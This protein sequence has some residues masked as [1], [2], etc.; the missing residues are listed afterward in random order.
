MCSAWI[1][2]WTMKYTFQSSILPLLSGGSE[3]ADLAYIDCFLTYNIDFIYYK[4]PK[5]VG[6]CVVI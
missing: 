4:I 5:L 2:C 6:F 1:R 3:I